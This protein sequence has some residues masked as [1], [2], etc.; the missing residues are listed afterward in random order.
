MTFQQ[1]LHAMRAACEVSGD[2]E[3]WI[4][5]SQAIPGV[6]PEA[7]EDLC[8]SIEV[9]VQPRN[10]PERTMIIDGALGELS[11]SSDSWLLCPRGL[12]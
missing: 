2:N 11:V 6:Y 8:T 3:L 1:L 9:D 7:P 12:Y 4:F 5:G 10:F